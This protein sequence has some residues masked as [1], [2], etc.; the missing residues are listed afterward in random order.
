MFPR[1]FV[2]WRFGTGICTPIDEIPN[3]ERYTQLIQD[4][5]SANFDT[6]Y[7]LYWK[8]VAQNKSDEWLEERLEALLQHEE[9]VSP[10]SEWSTGF[11]VFMSSCIILSVGLYI[12]SITSNTVVYHQYIQGWPEHSYYYLWF[13]FNFLVSNLKRASSLVVG[14]K[15]A[16]HFFQEGLILIKNV[17]LLYQRMGWSFFLN[18]MSSVSEKNVYLLIFRVKII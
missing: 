3:F 7:R 1:K 11:Y 12:Y 5:N 13:F 18:E 15:S 4:V 9:K 16:A 6:R 2:C 14:E 10:N 8:D 17:M